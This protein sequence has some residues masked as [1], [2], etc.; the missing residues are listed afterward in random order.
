MEIESASMEHT[1]MG[2]SRKFLFLVLL[3]LLLL[4]P[5]RLIH[6][7]SGGTDN[8]AATDGGAAD[9]TEEELGPVLRFLGI[10]DPLVL[11]AEGVSSPQVSMLE[12]YH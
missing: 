2:R 4:I 5:S 12:T 11:S 6:G 8:G 3:L 7:A 10:R 9:P 1:T